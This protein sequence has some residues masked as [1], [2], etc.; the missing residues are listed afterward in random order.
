MRETPGKNSEQAA[1][2][3]EP[4]QRRGL[5]RFCE[6]PRCLLTITVVAIFTAEALVM[7]VLPTLNSLSVYMKAII[8]S[9]LLVVIVFPAMY[10]FVLKPMQ[11]NSAAIQQAADRQAKLVTELQKA[12][13][14]VKTLSGLLPICSSC[15]KIRD[16]KGYWNQIEKYLHEHSNIDFT[17]GI[18]PDCMKKLYPEFSDQFD[19]TEKKDKA[20]SEKDK[21]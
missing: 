7:L 1:E 3:K 21:K 14:E 12:L 6:N 8:D 13:D 9:S 17:H 19:P 5:S 2:F 15:K 18:C 20:I 10:F 16:D 4:A 11:A